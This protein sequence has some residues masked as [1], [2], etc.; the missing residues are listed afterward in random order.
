[1]LR[2]DILVRHFR[3][4]TAGDLVGLHP[5]KVERIE[6]PSGELIDSCTSTWVA[7]D[8]D[9]HGDGDAPPENAIAAKVWHQR[10]SDLG[11]HPLTY[12]SNGRGGYRFLI[13]FSEPIQTDTAYRFIRWLQR[14]WRELGLE[15]EPEAFPKQRQLRFADDS[16]DMQGAC[17][18]WLRLF[19]RHH[20]REHYS[21]F[22]DGQRTL[23]GNEA[24]D[25]LLGHQGDDPRLIPPEVY[26]A[27]IDEP[28]QKRSASIKP[29]R[30]DPAELARVESAL[31]AIEV[32]ALN[33]DAWLDTGM[34]LHEMGDAGLELWDKWSRNE[35]VKTWEKEHGQKKYEDGACAAKWPTFSTA[36]EMNGR[37][38]ITVASI[39]AWAK[40][41]GW[42]FLRTEAAT[43]RAD[44][45]EAPT[46]SSERPWPPL[47]FAEPP[48]VLSF[49]VEVFP[50]ALRQYCRDL[51]EAT[52]AP[53]DFV[54]LSMLVTAG[55][56]IGQSVNIQVK[57]G[58]IETP[59]LFGLLLGLP[60]K[61]KTPVAHAVAKPLKEIDR[62]VRD[63]S[64]LAREKWKEAKEAYKLDPKKN[65]PPGPEPKQ[66]RAVVNDI[67]RESLAII[68][69]DNERGV[70]CYRDE[71]VG[72]IASFNEYKGR[73]GAD[74]QFWLSDWSST[75]VSIDRKGGRES[76]DLASPFVSVLGG[77][78]PHL[79]DRLRDEQGRNDGFE[80]RI[81]F[82][83]PDQF[84][85]QE[86]TEKALSPREKADW[87]KTIECLYEQS[88]KKEVTFTRDAKNI[89]IAWFNSHAAEIDALDYPER[90]AGTWS[91]LRAH[92]ARLAL[93]LSRLRIACDSAP[94]STRNSDPIADGQYSGAEPSVNTTDVQGAI[95]LVNYFKSHLLRVSHQLT[96]GFTSA[97]TMALVNWIRRT[98]RESF[99]EADVKADLRRFRRQPGGLYAA[100]AQ[101]KALGIIRPKPESISRNKRGPKFSP[102]YDVHP[103]L[104]DAPDITANTNAPD[105]TANTPREPRAGTNNGFNGNLGRPQ[106][107]ESVSDREEFEL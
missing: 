5:I 30:T 101:A 65:K 58:W 57:P 49:P 63:Q 34:A 91:K 88:M 68:L 16:S 97:D 103:D 73:G 11:F 105:I 23:I 47:R 74:R 37:Q 79:L 92:A 39:F 72:W 84:P 99:R 2:L 89:W 36:S 78:S 27:K 42:R 62:R 38:G 64:R 50:V 31:E 14:D 51:A 22:W 7:S 10:A 21:R 83:F 100:L 1:L 85:P 70:L 45:A 90:H 43:P 9:H 53:T 35:S 41:E 4:A 12:Q 52:L 75:P 20:K 95:T 61:A 32:R 6:G 104:L 59:L 46:Q 48:P 55:A 17:G 60:G 33:Y 86:W 24:I 19:G 98:R 67:T 77:M 44:A 81:L 26:E 66:L 29:P 18:N 54:G 3:P 13:L 96:A 93:I 82:A 87:I 80:D 40:Q 56:A 28:A 8:I 69:N 15:S 76:I 106:K 94:P 102:A 107:D 25:W 71:A